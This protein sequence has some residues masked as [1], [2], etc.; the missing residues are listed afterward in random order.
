M[1]FRPSLT[2]IDRKEFRII[3]NVSR[4]MPIISFALTSNLSGSR[5]LI[6]ERATYT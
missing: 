4:E 5:Y 2:P 6:F 3:V 1:R